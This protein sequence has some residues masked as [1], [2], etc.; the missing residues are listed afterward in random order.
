[1]QPPAISPHQT[2]V[3]NILGSSPS[4]FRLAQMIES[5]DIGPEMYT[6]VVR[7]R[8][9]LLHRFQIEHDSPN[10]FTSYFLNA[11]GDGTN[12]NTQLRIFRDPDVFELVLRYLNGYQV[13][14][15]QDRFV[16]TGS[17]PEVTLADLRVDAEF[18][19]LQGLLDLCSAS[20]K[21][22]TVE[23]VVSYA[24]VEG[25]LGVSKDGM[26]PSEKIF[27]SMVIVH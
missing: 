22:K 15:I 23:L 6:V 21:D 17:T 12:K 14:P 13:V 4:I 20:K 25:S 26:S 18:Y 24:I 27:T 9:F 1:M 19:Q 11:L 10:F 3:Q 16:P 2:A 8:A 7:D 5:Q